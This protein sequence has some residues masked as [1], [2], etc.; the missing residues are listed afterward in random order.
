M[1]NRTRNQKEYSNLCKVC[2]EPGSRRKQ[3]GSYESH[4]KPVD[5]GFKNGSPQYRRNVICSYI[6]LIMSALED[7]EMQNSTHATGHLFMV[8]VLTSSIRISLEKP[9]KIFS[10]IISWLSCTEQTCNRC[11][12]KSKTSMRR[13]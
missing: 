7:R 12:Q 1:G 11:E 4:A 5:F 6:L 8:D 10:S 2:H 13:S 3:R 9:T